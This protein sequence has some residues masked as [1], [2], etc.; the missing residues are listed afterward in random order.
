[1]SNLAKLLSRSGTLVRQ[2]DLVGACTQLEKAARDHRGSAE[3]WVSLAA[4]HGMG[5]NYPEA[6]RCARKAV[7]LA[8]KS[9]QGWVNLANAAQ[10]CGEPAQAVEAFQRAHSL[11]GCP[12]D[13]TLNLGV[14]LAE[15][16]EW[17]K[18]EEALERNCEKNQKPFVSAG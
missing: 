11:P 4:V 3:P 16:G 7:E 9:L 2:G 5:G 17:A 18:A 6:L 8:P 12:P 15:L 1:M 13:I 10:S 14:A